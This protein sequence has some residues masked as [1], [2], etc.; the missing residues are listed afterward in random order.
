MIGRRNGGS[1]LSAVVGRSLSEL[2]RIKTRQPRLMV[3]VRACMHG[4]Q[5]QETWHDAFELEWPHSSRDLPW[6]LASQGEQR[7]ITVTL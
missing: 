2:E 4:Q 5:D 6:W 1:A 7:G 3:A